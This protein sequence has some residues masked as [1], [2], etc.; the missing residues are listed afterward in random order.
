MGRLFTKENF[1]RLTEDERSELMVL[2]MAR[3]GGRSDYLPDDCSE[4]A[5]CSTP[6]LGSGPHCDR[7]LDRLIALL[8]KLEAR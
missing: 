8:D 5:V 7:C 6:T 3:G 4:C 1:Q 2:Q